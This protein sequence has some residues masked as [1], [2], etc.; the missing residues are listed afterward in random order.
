MHTVPKKIIN[1]TEVKERKS[2]TCTVLREYH[3]ITAKTS[4]QKVTFAC[5][6]H[7]LQTQLIFNGQLKF[8]CENNIRVND[9]CVTKNQCNTLVRSIN[10]KLEKR[11]AVQTK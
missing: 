5:N 2:F 10:V 7:C 1:E 9:F 4:T 11:S 6:L 3:I 8:I